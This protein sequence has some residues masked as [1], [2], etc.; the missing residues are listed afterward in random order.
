[1]TGSVGAA[2]DAI[3]TE[4]FEADVIVMLLPAFKYEV[5]S[6]NFVNEPDKPNVAPKDPV[7]PTFPEN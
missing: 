6:C 7:T 4:P 2:V 5:P 3:V 1:M